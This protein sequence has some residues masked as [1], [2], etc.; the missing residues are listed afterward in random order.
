MRLIRM[1]P[2][3]AEAPG[4]MTADGRI[5]DLRRIYPE[6]PDVGE[7]FFRGGWLPKVAAVD[8]A[9][10][11]FQNVRLGPPVGRSSKIICLGKNYAEHAREGGWEDLPQTPLLFCKA[12]SALNGPRDPVQLPRSCGQVDWEVELAVVIGR[13]GKRIAL[14]EA[15]DYVAGVTV[16]N[17]VSARDAQFSDGQW[18]RGKSCDTFAPLGPA[19]VTLDEIGD[20]QQLALTA[21]VNGEVMQAGNTADMIFDVAA[22]VAFISEDITLLPG[23]IISTGTPSGVGIFRDP[24]RLLA[25]GDIVECRIETIGAIRNPVVSV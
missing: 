8:T 4:L 21:T 15:L 23:D 12:P 5:L 25:A 11:E 3:G 10:A 16:M 24:P 19:L 1:G 17:D 20:L 13:S 22:L 2:L 9:A 18:F 7:A 14:R 6:I